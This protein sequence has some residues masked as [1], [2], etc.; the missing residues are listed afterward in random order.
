M[1]NGVDFHPY[2]QISLGSNLFVSNITTLYQS[3]DSLMYNDEGGLLDRSEYRKEIV[4][5]TLG[6]LLRG[7]IQYP[8]RLK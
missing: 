4:T 5:G 6:Y 1:R 8:T 3:R 7:Y 2:I